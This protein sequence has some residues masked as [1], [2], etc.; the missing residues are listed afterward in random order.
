MAKDL[1]LTDDG[2]LY[3]NNDFH[4]VNDK[5][6]LVQTLD[7][8]LRT[9]KGS[10]HNK[11]I[12]LDTSFLM[13]RFDSNS[14]ISAIKDCLI[15]DKRVIDVRDISVEMQANKVVFNVHLFTTHGNLDI[16]KGYD[17]NATK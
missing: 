14:A 16:S 12:G 1:L 2:D 11:D 10:A 9:E 6:E 5:I 17:L 8:A 7:T 3:L 15:K 13:G 4:F